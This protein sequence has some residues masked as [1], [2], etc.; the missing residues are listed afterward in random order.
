[1]QTGIPR[2]QTLFLFS[3]FFPPNIQVSFLI[4]RDPAAADPLAF[5]RSSARSKPQSS[6]RRPSK[7]RIKNPETPVSPHLGVFSPRPLPTAS[8]PR[9]RRRQQL[10][11]EAARDQPP[12]LT[13]DRAR[14]PGTRAQRAR[15]SRAV[16]DAARPRPGER[17]ERIAQS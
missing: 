9:R 2:L 8:L 4:L 3:V 1:M 5:T 11:L 15:L 12:R 6:V 7:H 13:R 14:A 16:P 17:L 10:L